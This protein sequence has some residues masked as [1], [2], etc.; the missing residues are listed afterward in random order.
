MHL[1]A[2]YPV[3]ADGIMIPMQ[4]PFSGMEILARLLKED[5]EID[6]IPFTLDGKAG[7]KDQHGRFFLYKFLNDQVELGN[8]LH[9]IAGTA[10][11]EAILEKMLGKLQ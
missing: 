9:E 8:F 11:E 10:D 1:F 7:Y 3:Q 2:Q 5:Y 4:L 6:I